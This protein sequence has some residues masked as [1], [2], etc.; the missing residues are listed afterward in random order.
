MCTLESIIK[1]DCAVNIRLKQNDE[2]FGMC[3]GSLIIY[4]KPNCTVTFSIAF[5]S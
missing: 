4:C 3:A 2:V 1:M 5:P